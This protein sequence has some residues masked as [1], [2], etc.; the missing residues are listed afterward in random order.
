MCQDRPRRV[1]VMPDHYFAPGIEFAPKGNPKWIAEA[2]AAW[3]QGEGSEEP[4]VVGSN[5]RRL[6]SFPALEAGVV[7]HR[8]GALADTPEIQYRLRLEVVGARRRV[9]IGV[10]LSGPGLP[11]EHT[12]G[13]GALVQRLVGNWRHRPEDESF[14]TRMREVSGPADVR[15][16]FDRLVDQRRSVPIVVV[17]RRSKSESPVADPERLARYL[18]G[19]AEVWSVP[20]TSSTFELGQQFVSRGFDPRW[21]CYD[22]GVRLYRAGLDPSVDS[23]GRHPLV[24]ASRLVQ[25][26]DATE[27]AA[28]WALG[29]ACRA[30]GIDEWRAQWRDELSGG[31]VSEGRDE[32]ATLADVAGLGTLRALLP[33]VEAQPA[34]EPTE[35]PASESS[36]VDAGQESVADGPSIAVE[37]EPIEA[38]P[39]KPEPPTAEP[40]VAPMAVQPASVAN[41][42]AREPPH[43]TGDSRPSRIQRGL[44]SLRDAF[45]TF[46]DLEDLL[47]ELER[48]L[49]DLREERDALALERDELSQALQDHEQQGQGLKLPSSV[50]EVLAWFD[51]L[52]GD[53]FRVTSYARR[54]ARGSR[55]AD[56]RLLGQVLSVFVAAGP[57]FG[58]VQR[59]LEQRVAR[60]ARAKPKDSKQTMAKFGE[61]RTFA[62]DDGSSV[63]GDMHV[64]LGHG[65]RNLNETMQIYWRRADDGATEIVYAGEHL[66]TVSENT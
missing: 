8:W 24:L 41:P 50:E 53:A 27:G 34:V 14:P 57:D 36:P 1:V 63:V 12:R 66:R 56:L 64:T 62:L 46:A 38:E 2:I 47:A 16:L 9:R 10:V 37:P 29:T 5:G 45:E 51:E 4:G 31:R 49:A 20:H 61:A 28:S 7:A 40:A 59:T 39:P 23:L 65:S 43:A 11:D 44:T 18:F 60:R 21:N 22:G 26:D 25:H 17:T 42:P 13:G 54:K 6:P 15:G 33:D 3:E 19:M 35:H 52:G 55:F 32:G 48:E 58:A 30:L